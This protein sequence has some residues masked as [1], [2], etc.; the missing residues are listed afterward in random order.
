MTAE[1]LENHLGIILKRGTLNESALFQ[2]ADLYDVYGERCL[3]WQPRF[4]QC[5]GRK[6]LSGKIRTIECQNGNVLLR[7]TLATEFDGRVLVVGRA[8]DLGGALLGDRISA[9]GMSSGW[10]KDHHPWR[11]S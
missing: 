6:V 11:H 5:G 1:P 3:S 8:T 7:K 2:N 10:S 9:L 4:K